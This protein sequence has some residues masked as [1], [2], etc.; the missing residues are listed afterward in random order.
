MRRALLLVGSGVISF[1][2]VYLASRF[3]GQA[4]AWILLALGVLTIILASR[5]GRRFLARL[6]ARTTEERSDGLVQLGAG[7]FVLGLAIFTATYL[8]PRVDGTVVRHGSGKGATYFLVVA[9]DGGTHD[10]IGNEEVRRC[11]IGERVT[12]EAWT[13]AYTCGG[14]HVPKSSVGISIALALEFAFS[15][16]WTAAMLAKATK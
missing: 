3:H 9:E 14:E 11:P 7:P 16:L 5:A 2:I 12:K 1:A 8:V 10:L 13:L 6:G 15:W 4:I